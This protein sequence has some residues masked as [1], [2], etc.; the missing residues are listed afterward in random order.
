MSDRPG[1]WKARLELDPTAFIAPGAV[2]VGTVRLGARSSVWFN[3]V[4]RGD[5]DRIEIGEDSNVQDNSTVHVDHGQPAVVGARVTIGHRAIIHGCVIE[6]DCLIGMGAVVLSGARIGA[7]S[8]I[9]AASLVKEGQ[10]IAPGSLALGSPARVIGPVAESHR[11]SIRGG[12]E[13]YAELAASYLGRGFTRPHP[14]AADN[15]GVTARNPGNPM[16]HTEWGAILAALAAAPEWAQA[17]LER[18]GAER[19]S[20][21]PGAGRWAASEVVAHLRTADQEVFLPRLQL[22]LGQESP[23]LAD[24]PVAR[25]ALEPEDRG[26][27]GTAILRAW[28]GFRRTLVARLERLGPAEWLRSGIHARRGPYSVADLARACR[29][30][31]ASHRRQIARAIGE[32]E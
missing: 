22:L 20:T 8:L 24:V 2:V 21:P 17:A 7:G 18:H 5:T 32:S 19:W 11:A 26:R 29:E 1:E 13:H 9:G 16:T 27:T 15:L 25:R 12:A 28:S 31:D 23:A 14:G 4:V 6:D 30:H 10:V 3:T